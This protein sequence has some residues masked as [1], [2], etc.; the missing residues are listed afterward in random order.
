[1]IFILIFCGAIG[2]AAVILNTPKST[3][4]VL[5]NRVRL[6]WYREWKERE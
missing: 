1:M 6:E 3:W 4:P 5:M 2:L